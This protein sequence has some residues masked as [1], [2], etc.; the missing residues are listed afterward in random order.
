MNMYFT[1]RCFC[2]AADAK[3]I[4]IYQS[5]ELPIVIIQI[6][7]TAGYCFYTWIDIIILIQEGNNVLKTKTRR[8]RWEVCKRK[9][10]HVANEIRLFE[11]PL[12]LWTQLWNASWWSS[13]CLRRMKGKI[14]HETDKLGSYFS[15]R[16]TQHPT[17]INCA[18]M[19]SQKVGFYIVYLCCATRRPNMRYCFQLFECRIH[20]WDDLPL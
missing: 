17:H 7:S 14:V 10:P 6:L 15:R 2:W 8:G 19:G 12:I 20:S 13:V 5:L 1:S 18:I 3:K 4:T 9:M 16:P 11:Q